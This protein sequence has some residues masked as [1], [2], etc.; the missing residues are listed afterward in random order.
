MVQPKSKRIV[1]EASLETK[2]ASDIPAAIDKS[3]S[4]TLGSQ[5]DG[6]R[7]GAS[8]S[9]M[10]C[11][12]SN[13]ANEV[14]GFVAENNPIFSPSQMYSIAEC[15]WSDATLQPYASSFLNYSKANTLAAGF[16]FTTILEG[17]FMMISSYKVGGIAQDIQIW[18]D[19]EEVTEWYQGKR[20]NGVLQTGK[21]VINCPTD[22]TA[23]YTCLNFAAR[24]VYKVRVTG[25]VVVDG[26]GQGFISTNKNGKFHKPSKQRV[27]G[28]ISDSWYDTITAHTS[29]N[30]ASE[31]GAR[32]GWKVW[33][34]AVGGT[35]F[36][37]PGEGST[38]MQ[39]GSDA[40]FANLLKAPDLDFLL[41]NGSVND[42]GYPQ[43]D[44]V[45]AMKAFFAR[46]RTVRPDTPV[47]WQG[48]EPQ[49]YFEN[50]YTAQ[51]IVDR[52]E[53]LRATAA[54][55]ANVIGTI[56]PAKENWLTGSGNIVAPNGTGNQDFNIGSD[57]VH[58]S[59]GG[60][61]LNSALVFERLKSI[62]TWK[63]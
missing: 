5:F 10:K 38:P 15:N 61:R 8:V 36:V 11:V 13:A 49:S 46:W 24:G 3:R 14:D 34:M 4:R 27:A 63:V 28:I 1:T 17:D 30:A 19:D 7:S 62:R 31:L 12:V 21:Q 47:V 29:L 16:D 45:N 33:N 58:L 43:V 52:E 60:T 42:M 35:G 41:L 53:V 23:Y 48:L 56:L 44:V 2:M 50:I 6:A 9:G 57:G 22:S 40:V 37:N 20:S 25:P 18:I 51:A 54:A 39:F 55:D 26:L 59:S 32:M